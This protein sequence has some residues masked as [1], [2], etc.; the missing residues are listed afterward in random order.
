MHCKRLINGGPCKIRTCDQLVKRL[1]RQ[2]AILSEPLKI[3]FF[4]PRTEQHAL[5]DRP[6]HG[7]GGET[8]LAVAVSSARGFDFHPL[9]RLSGMP[10]AQ[11]HEPAH[12]I[13]EVRQRNPRADA[14]QPD[15][16]HYGLAHGLHLVPEDVLDA[17]T[18]A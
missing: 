12:I 10:R 13:G 18:D 7:W 15:A 4:T 11:L 1:N 5:I 14:C 17:G 6:V 8:L 2:I 16:P 3:R 9:S